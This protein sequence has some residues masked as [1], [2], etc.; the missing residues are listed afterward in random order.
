MELEQIRKKVQIIFQNEQHK[1]T[2]YYTRKNGERKM[3]WDVI[4]YMTKEVI[5]DPEKY[6]FKAPN[7]NLLK[8]LDNKLNTN[9]EREFFWSELQATFRPDS[10]YHDL[11]SLSFETMFRLNKIKEAVKLLI[12]RFEVTLP[13]LNLLRRLIENL[14]FE[15]NV[16]DD[17]LLNTIGDWAEKLID[18]NRIVDIRTK[19]SHIEGKYWFKGDELIKPCSLE[20][21]IDDIKKLINEIQ[22]SRLQEELLEDVNW[23]INQDINKVEEKIELF[24]MSKEL[25][26]GIREIEKTYRKAG[27]AFDFKTCVDYTRSFLENLNKEVIPKIENKC[28]IKFTGDISKAKEVIDYFGKKGVDFLI[29]KEQN[30]CRDVYGL[31]SDLGVHSLVSKREYAR[32]SKNIIVEM[33]LLILDRLEKYLSKSSN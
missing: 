30:L 8:A 32:I 20:K 12:E 4:D 15:Y 24:R 11:V 9:K 19:V 23:E 18:E 3:L 27:S 14:R 5:R 33:A 6:E 22:H 10:N 25:S 13:Y 31:A 26:E 2:I 28:G 7:V 21:Y 16:F 17:G 1:P 29:E